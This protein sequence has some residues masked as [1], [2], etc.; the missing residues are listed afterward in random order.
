MIAVYLAVK[1]MGMAHVFRFLIVSPAFIPVIA[2]VGADRK[3][4]RRQRPSSARAARN[5]TTRAD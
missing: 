5:P 4:P 3:I 1:L 2:S